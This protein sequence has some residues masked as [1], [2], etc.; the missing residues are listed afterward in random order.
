M[1]SKTITVKLIRSLH[2][3]T[4]AQKNQVIGLGLKKIGNE[5]TLENTPAVRGMIKKII[6][7]L[8]I[9]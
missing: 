2:G 1:K 8:E 7:M 5:R 4:Q 9:K 3:I 6:H